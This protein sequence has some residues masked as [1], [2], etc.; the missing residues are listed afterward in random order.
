MAKAPRTDDPYAD[1]FTPEEETAAAAFEKST[2]VPPPE[3]GEAPAADP[4]AA[5]APP[6]PPPPPP[7]APAPAVDPAA[8]PADPAAAAAAAAAAA[9]T[10][11]D[12]PEFKA[13]W[14][15]HKD[16]SP[17][18]IA[19]LAFQQGKRANREGFTA[20][21]TQEQLDDVARRAAETLAARKT[22]IENRR[23]AFDEKLKDDPDAAAKEVND[24][25][26]DEELARAE[27]DAHV[28][29]V[30]TAIGFAETY[31]PDF[32]TEYPQIRSFGEEIGYSKAE[33]NGITD[34]RDIVTLNLARLAGNLIKAGVIDVRGQ[35]LKA[36]EPIA[37]VPTDPRLTA[38]APVTTLSSAPGAPATAARRSSSS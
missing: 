4:A 1:H 12:D 17:E 16:K 13:W 19:R 14:D 24:R 5:A 30:D 8:A 15:K 21:K 26:L 38:P 36:P 6:P 11:T 7:P 34:G 29:R 27:A 23:K 10:S 33:L 18:E 3:D 31:I 28:T 35:F 20:R 22:D 2:E 9:G 37:Q 25:L 32:R